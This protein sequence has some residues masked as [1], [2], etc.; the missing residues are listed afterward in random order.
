MNIYKFSEDKDT[1]REYKYKVLVYPNITYMKDLEKDS[2]VVVLRNVIK[3]LNKVR[4]F[5]K[6]NK[7]NDVKICEKCSF[8][9]TYNWHKI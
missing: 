7:V 6:T 4:N 2:Y 9:D 3:E 1:D 5:H 8:K